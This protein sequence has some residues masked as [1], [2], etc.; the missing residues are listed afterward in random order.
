MRPSWQ[1]LRLNKS[2]RLAY[3]LNELRSLAPHVCVYSFQSQVNSYVRGLNEFSGFF[4]LY[5][6][7]L[8]IYY[9]P[10]YSLRV[11][12]LTDMWAWAVW[13]CAHFFSHFNYKVLALDK[14][15]FKCFS[16]ELLYQWFKSK[17]FCLSE[18]DVLPWDIMF[19]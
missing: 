16:L 12:V 7:I 13:V 17:K 6:I 4:Y 15:S 1:I 2:R 10:C 19:R 8:C 11:T 3:K 9:S 18:T 5:K 14:L